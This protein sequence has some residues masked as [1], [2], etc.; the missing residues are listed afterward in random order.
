MLDAMVAP[1]LEIEHLRVDFP[2]VV[3]V[4]DLSLT[5][6][7][8]DRNVLAFASPQP[9]RVRVEALRTGTGNLRM[10]F[11]RSA[12]SLAL[13]LA[14]V[15]GAALFSQCVF[16]IPTAWKAFATASASLLAFFLIFPLLLEFCRLR[17]QRRAVGFVALSLFVLCALPF[18]LAGVFSNEAFGRLS[19]LSPGV[20]ALN[21]PTSDELNYLM[22]T[23]LAHL[24]IAAVLFVA[25]RNQWRRLLNRT[26][27][28]N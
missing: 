22:L 12:A 10:V 20:V 23:V 5:I 2:E 6:E 14:A 9:E 8:G 3:A 26:T 18:V 1:L 21:D 15:A 11:S 7:P 28:Q 17:F 24:L 16:S 27:R 4:N 19:L 25:W 13:P